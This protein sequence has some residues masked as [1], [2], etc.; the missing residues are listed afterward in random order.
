[1]TSIVDI[2]SLLLAGMCALKEL[3]V[4]VILISPNH[5]TFIVFNSKESVCLYV[6][7]LS[8]ITILWTDTDH[9]AL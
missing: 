6:V 1:M 2:V 9:R 3:K 7:Y 8:I 5:I 4:S